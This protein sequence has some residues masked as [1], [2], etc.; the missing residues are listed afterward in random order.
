[1]ECR[2]T[3]RGR[4]IVA[5]AEQVEAALRD[6]TPDKVYVYSVEVG[7]RVYPITQALAVAFGLKRADCSPRVACRVFR[8]L[9]FPVAASSRRF[10][11]TGTRARLRE[12][13]PDRTPEIGPVE[14]GFLELP[15]IHLAWSRWERWE[16]VAEHGIAIIDLP[17]HT[18]GVYEARLKDSEERLTIGRASDLRIRLLHVL[19]W[20][21]GPHPAGEKIREHED[22]S[23]VLVRWAA[24]DRPAAAEEELHRRHIATFGHLPKYTSRT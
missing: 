20:G 11:R 17:R 19:I 16:D 22:L 2:F 5:T 7:G 3:V 23:Q 15:R 9:G 24:T 18:P 12:A 21:N 13:L 1:M 8:Q 10:R 14:N 6:V 4:R